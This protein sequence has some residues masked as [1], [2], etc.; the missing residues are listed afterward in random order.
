MINIKRYKIKRIKRDYERESRKQEFLESA[1]R[2]TP[3]NQCIGFH[4][5]E[6]Y[7]EMTVNELKMIR[8]RLEEIL[9]VLK[10]VD[11]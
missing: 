8:Q 7:Y 1:R 6:E 2:A 11:R 9:A 4:K 3:H 10:D 5:D